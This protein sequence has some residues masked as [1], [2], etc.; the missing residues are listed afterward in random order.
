[1]MNPGMM[2]NAK[3]MALMDLIKQMNKGRFHPDDPIDPKTMMKKA[4]T[5]GSPEEE[6]NESPEEEAQEDKLG[7]PDQDDN[8]ESDFDKERKSFMRGHNKP[9]SAPATLAIMIGSKAPMPRKGRGKR[10]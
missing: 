6:M 2:R 5:E 8:E 10:G 4:M 1:M 7:L 9:A 3:R